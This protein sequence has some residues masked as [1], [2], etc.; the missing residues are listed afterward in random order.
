MTRLIDTGHGTVVPA[1]GLNGFGSITKGPARDSRQ[2]DVPPRR[3][4]AMSNQ[5]TNLREELRKAAEQSRQRPD[6]MKR[7]MPTITGRFSNATQ[8]SSPRP[9]R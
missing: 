2:V 1:I 8:A 5:P 6:S 4:T 9:S 3:E 7:A